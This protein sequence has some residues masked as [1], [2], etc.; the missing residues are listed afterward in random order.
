VAAQLAASQEGLSS[1]GKY[2]HHSKQTVTTTVLP[3]SRLHAL[4]V[5]ISILANC[6]EFDAN[7]K[8]QNRTSIHT[9]TD[10]FQALSNSSF[11]LSFEPT[12]SGYAQRRIVTDISSTI[13]QLCK[14]VLNG[15]KRPRN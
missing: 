12:Q 3:D 8:W 2:V 4:A 10:F 15:R 9:T 1:V 11:V 14:P 7:K 13:S 5:D 6:T